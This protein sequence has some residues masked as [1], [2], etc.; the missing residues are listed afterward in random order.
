M[1]VIAVEFVVVCSEKSRGTG[2][3]TWDEWD[4]LLFC[5]GFLGQASSSERG[6]ADYGMLQAKSLKFQHYQINISS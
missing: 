5:W 4:V 1:A 2:L 6:E 3:W